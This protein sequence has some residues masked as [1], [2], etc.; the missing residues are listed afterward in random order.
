V[1]SPYCHRIIGKVLVEFSLCRIARDIDVLGTAK[2]SC[3]KF[4]NL[5]ILMVSIVL[6]GR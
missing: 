1:I 4:I 3:K 2:S 5:V 6:L